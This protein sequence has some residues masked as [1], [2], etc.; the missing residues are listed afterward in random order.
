MRGA[1]RLARAGRRNRARRRGCARQRGVL[2]GSAGQ[3]G[4]AETIGGLAFRRSRRRRFTADAPAAPAPTAAT[5][6]GFTCAGER[7]C[8]EMASCDEAKFY[9]SRCGVG[10][11]DGNKDGVPCEKLCR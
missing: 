9:L 2:T 8:R 1:A 5:S 7:Y 3:G 11:L 6:G 10:S 4:R